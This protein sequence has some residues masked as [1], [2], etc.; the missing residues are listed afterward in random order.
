MQYNYVAPC[1]FICV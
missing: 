1:N